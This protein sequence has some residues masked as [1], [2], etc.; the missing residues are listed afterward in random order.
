VKRWS[1][2]STRVRLGALVAA[3]AV[4]V[5]GAVWAGADAPQ[6][7]AV[8]RTAGSHAP[9][10]AGIEDRF[11]I[12]ILGAYVTAAGGMVE[13]QYQVLDADKALGI[14]DDKPVLRAHGTVF[15]VD[16]LAGHGHG[17]HV[18]PAGRSGFVL[19][20]NTKGALHSGD[21]VSVL[22]GDLTLDGVV[23]E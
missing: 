15:D 5:S 10:S 20:A 4:A 21:V 13:I 3:A 12:R 2:T 7:A 8:Q 16:G 17:H 11:G 1:A 22:V 19:L 23:L 14:A 6:P 9:R 18:P